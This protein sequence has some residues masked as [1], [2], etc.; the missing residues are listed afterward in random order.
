MIII[1]SVILIL[2]VAYIILLSHL[3]SKI[4][5]I[6]YDMQ[7]LYRSLDIFT[8]WMDNVNDS[9]DDLERKAIQ[10]KYK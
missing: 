2:L 7:R 8:K 6:E 3:S 5:S 4:Q 10:S 1:N 9:L